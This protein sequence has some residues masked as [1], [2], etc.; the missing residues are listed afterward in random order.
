LSG[1]LFKKEKDMKQILQKIKI[2]ATAAA[3]LILTNQ[4]YAEDIVETT[5]LVYMIGSDLETGYGCATADLEEMMASGCGQEINLIVQT[6]GAKSWAHKKIKDNTCQRFAVRDGEI[7][8]LQNIGLKS[9]VEPETLTEF[10]QWGTENF[11]AERY[12][13]ILWDHGGGTVSGFGY[14]ENFPEQWLSL[15]EI[16]E[17]LE[18]GGCHFDLVGFDA[19]LMGTVETACMLAPYADYMVASEE[20]VPGDGWD[21]RGWLR[22]LERNAQMSGAQ[23][24]IA[25]S[26]GYVEYYENTNEDYTISVIDLEKTMQLYNELCEYMNASEQLLHQRYFQELSQARAQ[27]K[28]FGDGDYEQIDIRDYVNRLDV[29]DGAEVKQSLDSCIVY[30]AGNIYNANG[31]A[32]YYPYRYLE[33][34]SA[35]WSDLSLYGYTDGMGAYFDQ[36]ASIIAGVQNGGNVG[37]FD[38]EETV[39]WEYSE[40]DWYDPQQADDYSEVYEELAY[41]ELEIIDQGEYFILPI[42]DEMWEQITYIEQQVYMDDGDGYIDLGCDNYYELDKNDNLIVDFDY[43]WVALD[44]M[45]VPYYAEVE[46]FIDDDQ[47]YTYGYV[48]ADLNETYAI[49][50][51]LRWDDKHEDGY[52]SG[53]R[54]ANEGLGQATAKGLYEFRPGDRIDICCDF[55]TYDGEF[56]GVYY[57]GDPLY[58][59][60]WKELSVSYE[61]IGDNTTLVNYML[62]D[63]YQNCYFTE[64]VEITME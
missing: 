48:P 21:Y 12:E 39:E 27:A 10:I 22:E 9:M 59:K 55:Y 26:E 36:F 3:I 44:G 13:L 24:G 56:E 53:W 47:W 51:V 33:D 62:T 50:I 17:A 8:E 11:P 32:M 28:A 14:D 40:Y 58:V 4:V 41:D 43:Y 35:V 20:Y 25:I 57:W 37:F 16:G 42:S 61:Y 63:V 18:L 52:V 15:S 38:S 45:I 6:G 30:N 5:V 31:L 49:E 64:T 46:E 54:Y 23:I 1:C 29:I 19:C 34:Y 2:A 7:Y 60:W